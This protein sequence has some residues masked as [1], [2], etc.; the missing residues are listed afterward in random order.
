MSKTFAAQLTKPHTA[1]RKNMI[2]KLLKSHVLNCKSYV[3]IFQTSHKT[4]IVI[5]AGMQTY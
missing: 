3:I 2:A 1:Y 5:R 4:Y